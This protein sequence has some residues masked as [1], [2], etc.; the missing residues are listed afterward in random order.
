MGHD[1]ATS[2]QRFE[3]QTR[4]R[5]FGEREPPI[6]KELATTHQVEC[7]ERDFVDTQNA[8]F[9]SLV[10]QRFQFETFG[11]LFAEFQIRSIEIR[12]MAWVLSRRDGAAMPSR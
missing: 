11:E 1:H 6:Q 9:V 10:K 8:H 7:P 3:A 12:L 2:I 5:F 4:G